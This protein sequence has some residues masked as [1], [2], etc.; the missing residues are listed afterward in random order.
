MTI[1]P[2]D[3]PEPMNF[4]LF[5]RDLRLLL[6]KYGMPLPWIQRALTII[7]NPEKEKK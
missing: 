1:K 4:D 3:V 2:E 6:I 7:F 5:L